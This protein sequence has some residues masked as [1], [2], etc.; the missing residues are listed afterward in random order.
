MLGPEERGC[1]ARF[2]FF[3]L[4]VLHR[5]FQSQLQSQLHSKVPVVSHVAGPTGDH[6]AHIDR[7]EYSIEYSVRTSSFID[8]LMEIC[9]KR[10]AIRIRV[11]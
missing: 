7:A 9:F 6:L 1:R 8:L 3:F 10:V 4:L 5:A 2:T 11:R